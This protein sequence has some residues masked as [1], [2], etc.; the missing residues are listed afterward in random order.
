LR[1]GAAKA[2]SRCLFVM[3]L[4]M[5]LSIAQPA[6]ALSMYAT[7][8]PRTNWVSV[9]CS[10]DGTKLV[11]TV[12][13]GA[14]GGIYRSADSGA[15]W[16]PTSAPITNWSSIASSADGSRLLAAGSWACGAGPLYVSTNL[17]TT[18]MQANAPIASW[19]S[20]ASSADGKRLVAAGFD[21]APVISTDFGATWTKTSPPFSNC[22]SVTSSADGQQLAVAA[23]S[24]FVSTNGGGAWNPAGPPARGT[25]VRLSE[26][27]RILVAIGTDCPI[28]VSTNLGTTWTTCPVP[29]NN[30]ANCATASADG[31]KW[32]LSGPYYFF[33][34]T[35]YGTTWN[36]EHYASQTYGLASSADGNKLVL[37]DGCYIYTSFITTPLLSVSQ[38]ANAFRLSWPPNISGLVVQTAS[39]LALTNWSDVAATPLVSNGQYQVTLAPTNSRG[40]FRLRHP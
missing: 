29:L 7:S 23:G 30:Y 27:G 6:L 18:W 20:V 10:A 5:G 15:T 36:S 25:C 1:I 16:T 31:R 24:I 35:D 26:D 4:L 32:V 14:R 9:A 12:G 40:F 39:D 17:G 3:T 19:C 11:A 33:V 34:S 8:A 21:E 28:Y 22:W 2:N 37:T 38:S 13:P